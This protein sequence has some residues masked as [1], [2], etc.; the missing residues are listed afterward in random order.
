MANEIALTSRE[1]ETGRE[2]RFGR[3][4][5]KGLGEKEDGCVE[6]GYDKKRRTGYEV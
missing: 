3:R 5:R 1:K 4:E 6:A 2:E